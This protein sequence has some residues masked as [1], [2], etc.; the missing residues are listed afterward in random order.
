VRARRIVSRAS[1]VAVVVTAVSVAGAQQPPPPESSGQTFRSSVD[2]IEVDV[3][4]LDKDRR[5]VRDLRQADFTVLEDGKPQK[6][7][8]FARLDAEEHDPTRSA[9]MSFAGTDIADNSLAER[10][11]NGRLFAIV[12][13][14]MNIPADDADIVIGARDTARRVVEQLRPSDQASVVYVNDAGK[15]QDFTSDKSKLFD[16]I[17][18]FVP[19]PP[20]YIAPKYEYLAGGGADMPYRYS[21]ILARSACLRDQPAVPT[22]DATTNA[23]TVVTGKRKTLIF[24]S[25]GLPVNFAARDKCGA[26]RAEIMKDVFRKAQRASINI[27]TIDPAG[28]NGY[29]LY[30]EQYRIR[31]GRGAGVRR[32]PPSD[33]R[34]MHD[35]LKIVADNTGGRVVVD[36]DAV[37]PG[38]DR[39]FEEEA[40]YYL[41]GYEASNTSA[42]GKFR[43]IQVKVNR[44]G[45]SIR[46]RSGYWAAEAGAVV[47][48]DRRV[49][50]D[51]DFDPELSGLTGPPGVALRAAASAVALAT[52]TIPTSVPVLSP[53]VSG[54]APA[55]TPPTTSLA[56]VVVALS[57]RWPTVRA[58]TPETLTIIRNVYDPDGRADTPVRETVSL[59][60][61]PGVERRHELVRHVALTPGRHQIR[62]NVAS[63]VL[64]RNG[65]VYVDVEVPDLGRSALA[66]SNVILG[67]VQPAGEPAADGVVGSPAIV[68]TSSR[69]FVNGDQIAAFLHVH[70][71]RTATTPVTVSVE[72]LDVDDRS[73]FSTSQVLMPEAFAADGGV[74]YQIALPLGQMTAGAH[75]LSMSAKLP[76]GRTVRRDLV[77]RVR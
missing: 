24:I 32:Q 58:T 11:G 42:D 51:L 62:F 25:P 74:N 46:S 61:E 75:L 21:P 56:D 9:R 57:V 39:I 15:T 71:P 72:V 30:I 77:F 54:R 37:L 33:V 18:R 76:N 2:V 49:N 55:A 44:P 22:L 38:V 13:D 31:N 26:Q 35:F 23:L 27:H 67:R 73:E 64:S 19:N 3:S 65:T 8:S 43:K 48:R 36:T 14:D 34:T 60:L 63:S 28:Y 47:V 69:D 41:L 70:Q 1:I 16:A 53:R 68:P 6:L 5:P 40:S 45:V 7:V 66:V 29:N 59:T 10:L 20:D 50:P 4:V 12:M 52:A 17:D